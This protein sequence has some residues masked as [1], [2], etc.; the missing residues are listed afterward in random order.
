[1]AKE[2]VLRKSTTFVPL[3]PYF[4]KCNSVLKQTSRILIDIMK[5]IIFKRNIKDNL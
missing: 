4:Q 1:M 3:A 2:V 5:A